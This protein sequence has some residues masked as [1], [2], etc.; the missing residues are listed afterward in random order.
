M[1]TGGGVRHD[2]TRTLAFQMVAVAAGFASNW[3]LARTLGPEGKGAVTY[4]GTTIWVAVTLGGLGFASAAVQHIGKRRYD[5]RTVVGVQLVAGLVLGVLAG[6]VAAGILYGAQERL[7]LPFHAVL[8][9]PP[10]VTAALIAANLHGVLIGRGQILTMN[11]LQ[12]ITPVVW[13]ATAWVV[14]SS[15]VRSLGPLIGAWFGAQFVAPIATLAVVLSRVPPARGKMREAAGS[16]ISFGLES[17]AAG[18]LWTLVLRLDALLLGV[19]AGPA[20]LGLYSVATLLGETLWYVPRALTL[21]LTPRIASRTAPEALSLTLRAVRM[22]VALVA[23]GALFLLIASPWL[24][25]LVFGDRFDGSIA[26]LR[27]LLP[28]IIA[29][30]VASPLALFVTQQS[31]RPRI[32]AAIGSISLVVNLLLNLWLIPKVGASGSAIASSVAYLL[33]AALVAIVVARQPGFSWRALLLARASDLPPIR[34]GGK[35]P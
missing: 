34:R 13:A 23:L 30:A 16:S 1:S 33:T 29:N 2:A 6:G 5:A 8:L 24:I 27:L 21:A 7:G 19:M 17:Y 22:G 26:P 25:H 11:R 3:I 4:V 28:G 31:G 12:V 18:L 20:A 10:L 35:R 15:G 9:A 32:N 14:L